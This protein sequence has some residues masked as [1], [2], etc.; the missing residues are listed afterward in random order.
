MAGLILYN[1]KLL[2]RGSKLATSL[3][4]CCDA[5]DPTECE[6]CSVII[7]GGV[8]REDGTSLEFDWPGV[9]NIRL[10]M[11]TAWSRLVRES[12]TVGYRITYD[13][14]VDVAIVRTGPSWVS[15]V[16]VGV[17]DSVRYK[18]GIDDLGMYAELR[19]DDAGYPSVDDD[20]PMIMEGTLSYDA[21]FHYTNRRND[22]GYA[23]IYFDYCD[24]DDSGTFDIDAQYCPQSSL[25]DFC[26]KWAPECTDCCFIFDDES[27]ED[28]DVDPVI[29]PDFGMPIVASTVVPVDTRVIN[30]D[31]SALATQTD[32]YGVSVSKHAFIMARL[33]KAKVC[34][35]EETDDGIETENLTLE[36]KLVGPPTDIS[37]TVVVTGWFFK[38]APLGS[39]AT[40]DV[41][42]FITHLTWTALN[43][44]DYMSVAANPFFFLCRKD[45]ETGELNPDG[46]PPSDLMVVWTPGE[47]CILPTGIAEFNLQF[48]ES[49]IHA[50]DRT[51]CC[52]PP[53]CCPI[54][55][56]T[57][58][59]Y[60]AREAGGV[61]AEYDVT[62]RL[63][64]V[65]NFDCE[66]AFPQTI[67][68][69]ITDG[70]TGLFETPEQ[71]GGLAV[72]CIFP[73]TAEVTCESD[74]DTQINVNSDF[75][76]PCGGAYNF[77]VALSALAN[78][79]TG[80]NWGDGPS[81]PMTV[82]VGP[83]E[84]GDTQTWEIEV[85]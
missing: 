17:P 4:C 31:E 72:A 70:P 25:T 18:R 49:L 9:A 46:N 2:R 50:C 3:Y 64:R 56:V 11:P 54:S 12:E 29:E 47:N 1:G 15:D 24:G 71:T 62:W 19:V 82:I 13:N 43:I 78:A 48:S 51:A 66:A 81:A 23:W 80:C 22:F 57:L 41:D 58:R 61:R 27:Q 63:E 38:T 76:S 6:E 36:I 84:N 35:G 20:E 37:G 79:N 69:E 73:P 65:S 32:L 16:L 39:V 42:G 55:Y 74:G 8:F 26:Y 75:S 60:G 45:P 77:L 83:D 67:S 33:D 14:Y 68:F 34:V 5:E 53:C 28:D 7:S 40:Y 59:A 52:D 21:H 30:N 10:T 44:G 85:F